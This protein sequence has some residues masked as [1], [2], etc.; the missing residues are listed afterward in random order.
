M[1][2]GDCYDDVDY[3]CTEKGFAN[4]QVKVDLP[5]DV[6]GTGERVVVAEV[7]HKGKKKEAIVQ[8]AL[9]CLYNLKNKLSLLI[10]RRCRKL[11]LK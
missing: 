6:M 7:N 2:G 1:I 5:I 8:C 3:V 9:V 11:V 10:S 4:F